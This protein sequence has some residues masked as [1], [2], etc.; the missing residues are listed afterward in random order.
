MTFGKSIS[1][2]YRNYFNIKGKASRSEYWWFQL[3]GVILGIV[4]AFIFM[5]FIVSAAKNQD[6]GKELVIQ[7]VY[8]SFMILLFSIPNITCTI[9]RLADAGISRWA[10][11]ILYVPIVVSLIGFLLIFKTLS[12]S[13][14]MGFGWTICFMTF[15]IGI[16][17]MIW[18]TKHS[19]DVEPR[20]I[21]K[22]S[23]IK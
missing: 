10:I 3:Y 7:I 21:P 6:F 20:S 14:L 19:C 9:R 2:C 18:L 11:L 1:S 22:K 23:N 15:Y 13:A 8:Y 4:L 16:L 12:F 17:F 5:P